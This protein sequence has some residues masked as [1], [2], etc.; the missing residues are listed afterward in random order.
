[1]ALILLRHHV[2]DWHKRWFVLGNDGQFLGYLHRE[3]HHKQKH[4]RQ[5]YGHAMVAIKVSASKKGLGSHRGLE[6][7]NDR[8]L[9]VEKKRFSCL[10]FS[11]LCMPRPK[12]I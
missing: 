11:W 7:R 8:R 10:S 12:L 9:A 5:K 6:A 4:A 1:M 2:M 3:H